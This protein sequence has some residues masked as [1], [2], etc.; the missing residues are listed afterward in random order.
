M[1]RLTEEGY[2]LYVILPILST[3]LGHSSIKS[4]ERYLRLTEE[5]LSTIV[6]SVQTNIPDVFPE[7]IEDAEF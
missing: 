7:V 4:T 5:R 1:N 2:D 3:Y 6:D